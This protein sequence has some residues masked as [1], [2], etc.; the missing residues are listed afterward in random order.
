MLD[1]GKEDQL[2]Q[3]W[4]DN[5]PLGASWRA[6]EKAS[7]WITVKERVEGN[8]VLKNRPVKVWCGSR[9]YPRRPMKFLYRSAVYQN[10]IVRTALRT[11][12]HYFPHPL[13]LPYRFQNTAASLTS[14]HTFK[15]FLSIGQYSND[16]TRT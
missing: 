15:T 4:V 7:G 8:K 10:Q 9:C 6:I 12:A 2:V 13:Q 3:G 1:R 16:L 11:S 14:L 5:M